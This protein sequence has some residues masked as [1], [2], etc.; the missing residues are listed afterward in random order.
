MKGLRKVACGL[1]V[2]VCLSAATPAAWAED[3]WV[4]GRLVLVERGGWIAGW[5]ERIAG[6]VGWSGSDDG[7]LRPVVE[8]STCG[9]DPNGAPKPCPSGASPAPF[10]DG[11]GLLGV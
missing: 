6:W 3:T 1:A 10:E 11:D 2:A 7:R 4:P 9:L 5:W 8:H